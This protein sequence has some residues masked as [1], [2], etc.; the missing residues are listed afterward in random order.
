MVSLPYDGMNRIRFEG[1]SV[2]AGQTESQ[3]VIAP[4]P[5]IQKSPQNPIKTIRR[6]FR[7][8]EAWRFGE[9]KAS[10]NFQGADY[11]VTRRVRERN[12]GGSHADTGDI[13]RELELKALSY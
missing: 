8:M 9:H 11:S 4:T 5:A 10:E 1:P 2:Y 12:K 6:W 13:G 7:Y 3:D